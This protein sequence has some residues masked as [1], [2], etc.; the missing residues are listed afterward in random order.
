MARSCRDLRRGIGLS[1]NDERGFTLVELL[2]VVAIIGVISAIAIVAL[3]SAVD[4]SRQRKTMATIRS[5]GTAIQTYSADLGHFPSD[6]L[7]AAELS[8]ALS[9]VTFKHVTTTDGWDHDLVYT[10]DTSDFTLESYGRDGADGPQDIG[11][12]SSAEYDYD[13]VF[14]NG[15]FINSPEG[16]E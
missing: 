9:G 11:K 16:A 5:A 10:A 4:K 3:K 7:T 12:S 15:Q 8:L 6:G 2:V 1:S 14:V 13:L